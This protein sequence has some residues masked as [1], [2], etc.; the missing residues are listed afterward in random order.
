MNTQHRIYTKKEQANINRVTGQKEK[1][2]LDKSRKAHSLEMKI[3]TGT[4]STNE[5]TELKALKIVLA[6]WWAAMVP[7]PPEGQ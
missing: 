1:I 4:I 3:I 7:Q 6:P 2:M 5:V